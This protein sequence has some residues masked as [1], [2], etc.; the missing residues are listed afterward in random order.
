MAAQA[1]VNS[2]PQPDGQA[3]SYTVVIT[4][5]AGQSAALAAQLNAAGVG[6]RYGQK[7]IHQGGKSIHFLQHAPNRIAEFLS[8]QVLLKCN[9]THASD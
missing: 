7:A 6:P 9:F 3:P 8:A 2:S 1:G 5:P 4:R